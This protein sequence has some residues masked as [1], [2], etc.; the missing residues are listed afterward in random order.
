MATILCVEDNP[1]LRALV[2][3]I[4]EARTA[5]AVAEEATGEAVLDLVRPGAAAD[6]LPDLILL[7]VEL[8]GISGIE[9]LRRLRGTAPG[10][11]IPVVMITAHDTPAMLTTAFD[12]KASDFIGKPFHPAEL[13][14]RVTNL[15][16]LGEETRLRRQREAELERQAW[17]LARANA[18]LQ[19]A[20]MLDP[21]LGIGN[22]RS[23]DTAFADEWARLAERGEPVSLLFVDVDRFKGINDHF[24]H[25]TGDAALKRVASVLQA[26]VAH[27]PHVLARYG[28]DEFALLLPGAALEQA[29]EIA[30]RACREVRE[31]ALAAPG[32][33]RPV[34]LSVSIGVAAAEPGAGAEPEALVARSDEALYAAKRAGRGSV[35]A[36]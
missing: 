7:D 30:D 5:H 31:V 24:G 19:T 2:R 34:A 28:G 32:S 15:L 17:E 13:V 16:R 10:R 9:T 12:E 23:F 11:D 26:A 29:T 1:V 21:L 14:A 6:G 33:E 4:L 22:R 25:P 36:A 8:P 35:R 18:M 20:S 27:A 3:E